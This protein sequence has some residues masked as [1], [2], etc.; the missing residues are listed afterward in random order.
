MNVLSS[1]QSI[2]ELLV[3]GVIK[4]VYVRVVRRRISAYRY[5]SGTQTKSERAGGRAL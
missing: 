4:D 2:G 3:E 1:A 5:M